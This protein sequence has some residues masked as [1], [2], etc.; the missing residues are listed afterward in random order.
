MG[1]GKKCGTVEEAKRQTLKWFSHKD[2]MKESK[3][4]SEI[5]RGNARG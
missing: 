1:E 4:T 5:E 3:R 2:G